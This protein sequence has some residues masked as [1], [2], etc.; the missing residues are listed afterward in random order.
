MKKTWIRLFPIFCIVA[1]GIYLSVQLN[2]DHKSAPSILHVGVLPDESEEAI[3]SRYVPLLKYLSVVTGLDV[4]LV[5]PANYNDLVAQFINNEIDIAYFGGLTF[6]QALTR[7]NAEPLVTRDVDTRFTSWFFVK[8]SDTAQNLNDYKGKRFSFGSRLSTSGHLMPRHFIQ[9][10][11]QIIP[12]QFFSEVSYSGTHD[13][14]AYKVRDGI[15]DIGVANSQII[16]AMISDGRLK[17]NDLRIIWQTPPYPDY[18]WAV[19]NHLQPVLKLQLLEAFLSLN[20]DIEEHSKILTLL[21]TDGF[22]PVDAKEYSTLQEVAE[23]LNMLNP[24]A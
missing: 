21:R 19:Q 20:L 24:E 1:Y 10:Q 8:N 11:F 23:D 6:V 3:R 12:E 17:E 13:T 14:T 2:Q 16:K 9:G 18:V 15:V 7:H 4:Q 5:L 22:L